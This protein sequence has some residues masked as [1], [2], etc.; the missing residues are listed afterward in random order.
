MPSLTLVTLVFSRGQTLVL[1][2][3]VRRLWHIHL[4]NKRGTRF[5]LEYRKDWN[6]RIQLIE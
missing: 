4:I 3:R 6:F 5:I 2:K 1:S